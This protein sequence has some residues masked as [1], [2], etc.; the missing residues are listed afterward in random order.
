MQKPRF[1]YGWVIVAAMG[2]A[3]AFSMA[4]G[5]LN[6][7]LFI[8]PIGNELGLGRSMFGWAFTSRQV[9]SAVTAPVVGRLIDRFGAR[10]LLVVAG[11][12]SGAALVGV[13]H[14]TQAWHLIA[15]FGAMG[16]VG[17][18]GPGAL[19]TSVPIAKW[20]VRKRGQALALASA[21]IPLGGVV[22][23]PLTQVFIDSFGWRDAWLWLAAI[24]AGT[25]IPIAI[26]FVRR[27]PEDMGLLPDGEPPQDPSQAAP[28]LALQRTLESSWTPREAARTMA[29]W[30][31][32][33]V[34]SI[35][36]LG[37]STVAIHRIPHFMDKGLDPRLVSYATAMDAGLAG[38]STF[39]IGYLA[40]RFPAR[41]LG[42]IGFA[43]LAIATLLTI[44]AGT[45][46][47][48]FVAMGT[49][50]VGIGAMLLMNNY[51]WADYFGREHLGAIRGIVNP[52]ILVF[53][54][55][56]APISGYVYD[57]IGTYNPIWWTG[58]A[59]LAAGALMIAVT[60]KPKRL[61][62]AA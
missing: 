44:I 60:P 58:L 51:L 55:A 62:P 22:F 37:M 2:L 13:A 3:G 1:F 8:K 52:F 38:L 24:G 15:L 26:V 5:T 49:F 9:A 4:L 56:G 17:M 31:L 27:Q 33:A 25:I 53:S 7:G 23:V 47:M 57:S 20:F 54:G 46:V 12:V 35:V 19:V 32:V 10:V 29:F 39:V 50:G 41:A 28:G 59:L 34:F 11:A 14:M 45:P 43:I 6:F 48:M 42:T 18:A 40:D 21:G 16:L 30:R 61:S 36:M